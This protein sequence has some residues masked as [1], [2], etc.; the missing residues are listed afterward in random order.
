MNDETE[1]CVTDDE[2]RDDGLLSPCPRRP[3][4]SHHH[5]RW[6]SPRDESQPALSDSRLPEIWTRV[7]RSTGQSSL[8]TGVKNLFTVIRRVNRRGHRPILY[9]HHTILSHKEVR[10]TPVMRSCPTAFYEG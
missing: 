3:G 4:R 7:S 5:T 10:P 6:T 1:L 2:K 8:S 9:S